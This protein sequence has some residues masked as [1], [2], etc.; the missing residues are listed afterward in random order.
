[1]ADIACGSGAFIC[2]ALEKMGEQLALIRMGDEERPTEDQLRE[3]KRDVLLHC[4]YGVDLNP[5]A[6]ELAKF[7]LWI[8][9]SLPDMPLTFLDH[10]LKCGNSLIGATPELIKK[11]IPEE[12]YKP[13]G[14]DNPAICTELKAK[15]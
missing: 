12:A 9:A 15:S 5:M 1:V 11:G 14:N 10:K 7:S 4:I 13:V 2:A 3:A 6:L 8:T